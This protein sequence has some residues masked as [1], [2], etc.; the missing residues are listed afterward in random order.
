MLRKN[1]GLAAITVIALALGV[2]VN[3]AVFISNRAWVLTRVGDPLLVR[4]VV[5]SARLFRI[6]RVQPML[7][8]NFFPEEERP[9]AN[10]TDVIIISHKLWKERFGGD[11]AILG[12]SLTL[13]GHLFSVVSCP[14]G[15]DSRTGIEN[16]DFWLTVAPLA[17]P[18]TNAARPVGEERGMSFLRVIGRLKT[19]VSIAQAQ[20]DMDRVAC[21]LSRDGGGAI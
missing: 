9:N 14:P 5:A 7:G 11:P 16:P 2:G 4:G 8:R 20:A 13:E 18:S 12:R 10:G 15:F 1:P 3:T 19:G 21:L 17:Q 6:L